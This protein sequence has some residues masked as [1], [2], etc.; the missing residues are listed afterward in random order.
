MAVLR[1]GED[2]VQQVLVAVVT[3]GVVAAGHEVPGT[4]LLHCL[5]PLCSAGPVAAELRS[6]SRS[7]TRSMRTRPT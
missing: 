2:P 4:E 7:T 1:P 6:A 3:D 5:P